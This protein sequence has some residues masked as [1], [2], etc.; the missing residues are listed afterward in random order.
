VRQIKAR[1]M[2]FVIVMGP[3]FLLGLFRVPFLVPRFGERYAE[4]SEMPIMLEQNSKPGVAM[5]LL[6]GF[7]ALGLSVAAELLLAAMIHSQSIL[8]YIASRDPISGSVYIALL[9]V[10][11]VMPSTTG[12]FS[13][14]RH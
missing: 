14:H 4:L 5:R 2:Y 11:A 8:Q 10:F 13:K 12:F 3:G 1:A 7:S 6:V 9:L